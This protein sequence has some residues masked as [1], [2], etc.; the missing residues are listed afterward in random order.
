MTINKT[1]NQEL[2][3]FID[4]NEFDE[5]PS[6][7]GNIWVKSIVNDSHCYMRV[8]IRLLVDDRTIRV[9]VGEFDSIPIGSIELFETRSLSK[10]HDLLKILS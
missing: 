9:Y 1:K 7:N 10:I 3:E 2:V 5:Y 4:H 6:E 8:F